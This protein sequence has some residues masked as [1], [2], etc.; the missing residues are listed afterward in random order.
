VGLPSCLHIIIII[1]II[2]VVVVVV[3][4]VSRDSSVGKATGYRLDGPGIESQWRRVFA[5]KS[6]PALRPTQSPIQRFPSL[7]RR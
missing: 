5:H 6:R 3:V 1:I 4:V 7:S 2:V